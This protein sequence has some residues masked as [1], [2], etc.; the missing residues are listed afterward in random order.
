MVVI[1]AADN[2]HTNINNVYGHF[3]ELTLAIDKVVQNI[4]ISMYT[5][6]IDRWHINGTCVGHRALLM[7]SM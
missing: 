2:Y 1:D 6:Y 7:Q 3:H 4:V 5:H